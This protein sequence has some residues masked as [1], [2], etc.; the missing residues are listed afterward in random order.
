MKRMLRYARGTVRIKIRGNAAERFLNILKQNYIDFW[1][2]K[3]CDEEIY[4]TILAKSFKKLIPLRR[5]LRVRI[6]LLDKKGFPF[7]KHKYRK[8]VGLILGIAL[9]LV[10]VNSLSN[11]IYS[12]EINGGSEEIRAKVGR[13]LESMGIKR[14]LS[15]KDKDFFVLSQR[16]ILETNELSWASINKVGAKIFVNISERSIPQAI[17]DKKTPCNI[18]AAKDGK[19]KSIEALTGQ[20]VVVTGQYVFKGDLLISAFV[21]TKK[22]GLTQRAEHATGRVVAETE[23][24]ATFFVPKNKTVKVQN[25][26]PVLKRYIGFDFFKIP[27][28]FKKNGGTADK[29]SYCKN[30]E[31]LYIELPIKIY[32][33]KYTPYV[34][35]DFSFSREEA[36]Q[37][38]ELQLK[39][40]MS[41]A[42]LGSSVIN[43][44]KVFTEDGERFILNV[45]ITADE[46]IEALRAI[47]TD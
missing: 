45:K 19:I 43:T 15:F 24:E 18:I 36:E 27:L 16:L 35:S 2:V 44:E 32:T 6:S 38:L 4:V 34:E 41:T 14:G 37:N 31:L 12:V 30:L 17:D 25:S 33:D 40:Y 22:E 23:T 42:F 10:V 3:K 29:E 47:E 8:R 9:F 28:N 46:R 13:N 5:K 26:E 20:R 1:D 21:E 39:N 7:L 11:F